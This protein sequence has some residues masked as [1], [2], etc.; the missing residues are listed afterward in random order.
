MFATTYP[1]RMSDTNFTTLSK[2]FSSNSF[3]LFSKGAITFASNSALPLKYFFKNSSKSKLIE[4][5]NYIYNPSCNNRI[6]PNFITSQKQ[7]I[8]KIKFSKI[9]SI[10]V[11][12]VTVLHCH[13]MY[14][15][16]LRNCIYSVFSDSRNNRKRR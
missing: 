4:T 3:I 2:L 12:A 16:K 6:T 5:F 8:V 15:K 7:S 10:N 1:F 11:T 9:T 14:C 13:H